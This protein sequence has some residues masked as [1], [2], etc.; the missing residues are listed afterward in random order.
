MMRRIGLSAAAFT[1]VMAPLAAKAQ[2]FE[3]P[4]NFYAGLVGGV[5]FISD[6]DVDVDVAGLSDVADVEIKHDMGYRFG[7]FLGYQIS[8]NI[9]VQADLSYIQADADNEFS[10][11]TVDIDTDQELSIISGTAGVYFDLWPIS[12]VVPYVGGGLGFSRVEITN[13][14]LDNDNDSEQDVLT[15]F[16]EA[17]VPFNLTPS[18]SV[19]PTLRYTWYQTEEEDDDEVLLGATAIERATIGKDLYS[20]DLMIAARY[21]F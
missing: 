19:A 10:F 9:R 20:T 17:G 14:D 13:D 15:F 12:A 7:G 2:S 5:A 11:G 3:P 4:S 16:A 21:N 8:T 18:F 6:Q 1:L